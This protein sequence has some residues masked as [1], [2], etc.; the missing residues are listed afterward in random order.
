M[1]IKSYSVHKVNASHS[2]LQY[3]QMNKCEHVSSDCH[4]MSLA[5]GW[6]S[7]GRHM[8]DI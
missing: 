3:I 7:T 1:N 5:G 6:A 2:T 4:Q 8:S